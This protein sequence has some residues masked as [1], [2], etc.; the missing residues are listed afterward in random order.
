MVAAT[1]LPSDVVAT[2]F[3]LFQLTPSVDVDVAALEAKYRA[4]SLEVH[5][6][7]QS[8]ADAYQRRLAAEKSAAL[9]EAVKAL[10][11]PLRRAFYLLEL[12]G[13]KLDTDQAAAQLK[14][15]LPFL[16]EIME[17]R[18]ALEGAK[19]TRDLTAAQ[20]MAA[21]IRN[22]R[23]TNLTTA[24]EALRK[25]EVS[26]AALALGKVRYYTRFLEEVDAF[27]EELIS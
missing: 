4:M 9:N 7:R 12:K 10:R 20:A 8:G 18:E 2:F 24:Q 19:A 17:R 27:E 15:P 14:M 11:D 21:E 23:D 13:V 3:E 5:P 22:A 25:D 16:E 1:P 26:S 6:D